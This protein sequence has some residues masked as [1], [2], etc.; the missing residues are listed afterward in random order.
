[1][2]SLDPVNTA[3][4]HQ[5]A[6]RAAMAPRARNGKAATGFRFF[7]STV[8][9]AAT[10]AAAATAAKP[11]AAVAA[12]ATT[13]AAGTANDATEQGKPAAEEPRERPVDVGVPPNVPAA[14]VTAVKVAVE[15]VAYNAR[16]SAVPPVPARE[17]AAGDNVVAEGER[18]RGACDEL[19]ESDTFSGAATEA[20][21]DAEQAVVNPFVRS[22]KLAR[23]PPTAAAPSAVVAIPG[24]AVAGHSEEVEAFRAP[25]P[26]EA[27]QAAAPETGGE[28]A[29]QESPEPIVAA[30]PFASKSRVA[31][32]PVEKAAASQLS[33]GAAMAGAG[34]ES[35]G[36]GVG[37]VGG[38]AA[39]VHN[40]EL[41]QE[42][43]SLADRLA[44][45][46]DE[47]NR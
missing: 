22:Q 31:R 35:A 32:T 43:A 25:S 1:M 47:R 41:R 29:G 16:E 19:C 15:S 4:T 44:K 37:E 14:A 39:R 9:E 24:A 18:A 12:A 30:D 33:R 2:R 23:T 40:W 21:Q 11:T 17:E 26:L 46:A 38:P 36:V 45:Q 10:A 8:E 27:T 28:R 7:S 13:H 6:S 5:P 20:V 34:G 3:T 42:V